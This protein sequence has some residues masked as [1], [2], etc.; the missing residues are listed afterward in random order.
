M[1][2]GWLEHRQGQKLLWG[3]GVDRGMLLPQGGMR[4]QSHP[5]CIKQPSFLEV[6]DYTF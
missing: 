4:G 1:G 6:P 5:G 2:E 3:L